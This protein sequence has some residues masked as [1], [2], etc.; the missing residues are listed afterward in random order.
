MAQA[1]T[2]TLAAA[3]AAA[4]VLKPLLGPLPL[5]P[6][7]KVVADAL[8]VRHAGG[9]QQVRQGQRGA[10]AA[11]LDGHLFE[12]VQVGRVEALHN[13]GNRRNYLKRV[14]AP[15][16]P[17]G[18]RTGTAQAATPRTGHGARALV[19]PPPAALPHSPS[20]AS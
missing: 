8:Q 20:S 2:S 18:T 1:G 11:Q 19:V 16:C 3:P 14:Q 12:E 17:V 15:C 7:A 13:N 4:A 9:G 10:S 5:P 6:A